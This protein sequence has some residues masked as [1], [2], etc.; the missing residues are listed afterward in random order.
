MTKNIFGK[1][2]GL[3][4]EAVVTGRKAGY[5]EQDWAALAHDLKLSRSVLAFIREN[6]GKISKGRLPVRWDIN[7]SGG[8]H[9]TLVEKAR[10]NLSCDCEF[11]QLV[12]TQFALFKSPAAPLIPRMVQL[13][14]LTPEELGI[15]GNLFKF[16]GLVSDDLGLRTWSMTHLDGQILKP[17]TLLTALS[18]ALQLGC[19]LERAAKVWMPIGHP[20]S[21]KAGV[22]S[23]MRPGDGGDPILEGHDKIGDVVWNGDCM[24]IVFEVCEE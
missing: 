20:E 7:S 24:S 12:Q 3:V 4:H 15:E 13:V 23:M 10:E 2:L 16:G 18:L 1:D 17:C 22:I 19:G 9:Q 11:D 8:T 21:K 6:K 5:T 14:T